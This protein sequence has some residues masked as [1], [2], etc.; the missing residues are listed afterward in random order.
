MTA[1]SP[2]EVSEPF[3][4]S[5]IGGRYLVFDVNVVTHL[6]R[7]LRICGV[8]I[9]SIPQLPQQN[10]FQG[11]PL[12]LL[13]E[14]ARLLVE[15]GSAYVVDD[16]AIH[17]EKFSTLHGSE[18][19]QYLASLR[20]E[21]LQA[22]RTAEAEARKRSELAL[23]KRAA[24]QA[25]SKSSRV[26][27]DAPSEEA[28]GKDETLDA[29]LWT[30]PEATSSRDS[31]PSTPATSSTLESSPYLITRTTSHAT[32]SKVA[33]ERI[34]TDRGEPGINSAFIFGPNRMGKTPTPT[35]PAVPRALTIAARSLP[36]CV[37]KLVCA[38]CRIKRGFSWPV[39]GVAH[40]H[41]R[42]QLQ[43]SAACFV[44]F[45]NILCVM[46]VGNRG[47]PALARPAQL[48]C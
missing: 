46:W 3:P 18:R 37:V 10:I 27:P 26:V 25:T 19:R 33:L 4:I 1:S 36:G 48:R 14:E 13:P 6:R 7:D 15:N 22:R 20:E 44:I 38:V 45:F 23:A 28:S 31:S 40:H 9:G 12:Q 43:C 47:V 21:G 32:P 5:V 17:R 39:S 8:L 34:L 24:K 29:S 42:H 11:L 16:T 30:P 35:P 41:C 2:T